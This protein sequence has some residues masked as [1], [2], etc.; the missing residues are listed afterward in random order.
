[1]K[2]VR[3]VVHLQPEVAAKLA[4]LC[5]QTMREPSTIVALLL[6]R[7][8]PEDLVVVPNERA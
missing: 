4:E 6:L 2:S 7:A 3:K 5:A 1:M 8:R